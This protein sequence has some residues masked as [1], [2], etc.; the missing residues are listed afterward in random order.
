MKPAE[1]GLFDHRLVVSAWLCRPGYI[2]LVQAVS[3]ASL[4]KTA[5]SV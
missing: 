4:S 1:I 3:V 5:P 2:S